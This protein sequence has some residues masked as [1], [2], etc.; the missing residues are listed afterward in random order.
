MEPV[1]YN[2]DIDDE[3]TRIVRPKFAEGQEIIAYRDVHVLHSSPDVAYRTSVMRLLHVASC[4][5]RKE[6]E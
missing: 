5:A 2:Q 4:R 3:Y 6:R 1:S